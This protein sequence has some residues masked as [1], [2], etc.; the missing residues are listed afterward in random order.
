[1]KSLVEHKYDYHV[2]NYAN[3]QNVKDIFW[4]HPESIK[5]FNTFPTV[6]IMDST[7]KTNKYCL[8]LL[9]FVGVTSTYLTYSIA[10]AYMMSE[11]EESVTWALE[12]CRGLF[13]SVNMSPEGVVTDQDNAL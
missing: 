11:K 5:V 4:A 9:E 7:Y 3:S 12:R 13:K 6:L 1:M 8:P 2:R 10:F